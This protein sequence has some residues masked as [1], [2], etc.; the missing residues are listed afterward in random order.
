MRPGRAS[1]CVAA[2]LTG[3]PGCAV[4]QLRRW[5]AALPLPAVIGE[6]QGV[7]TGRRVLRARVWNGMLSQFFRSVHLNEPRHA[8]KH[9]LVLFSLYLG[10]EWC[11]F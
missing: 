1:A 4:S 8:V 6:V 2:G 3:A 5:F 9:V 10:S 7:G 11:I